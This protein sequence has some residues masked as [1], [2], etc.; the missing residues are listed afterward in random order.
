MFTKKLFLAL[1]NFFLGIWLLK[2][3]RSS[4]NIKVGGGACKAAKLHVFLGIL[5]GWKSSP[6]TAR[7]RM[8]SKHWSSSWNHPLFR[9]RH[10]SMMNLNRACM[11]VWDDWLNGS[12]WC[13]NKFSWYIRCFKWGTLTISEIDV[14]VVRHLNYDT[15][16]WCCVFCIIFGASVLH[17]PSSLFYR[18]E[19]FI[20]FLNLKY[21]AAS[22]IKLEIR[23]YSYFETLAPVYDD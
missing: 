21:L 1:Y 19:H 3:V 8:E 4:G 22:I 6:E 7:W 18:G 16:G 20:Y 2:Q 23:I 17:V 13:V 9:Y 12:S 14:M 5:W 15:Y 11:L 10:L